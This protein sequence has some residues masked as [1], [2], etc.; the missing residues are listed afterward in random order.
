MRKSQDEYIAHEGNM[1]K[2]R[3]LTPLGLGLNL[4]GTFGSFSV[5]A[6]FAIHLVTTFEKELTTMNQKIDNGNNQIIQRIDFIVQKENSDVLFLTQ[7]EASD[8]LTLNQ[9]IYGC[10]SKQ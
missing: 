1:Q 7:K 6:W 4:I 2:W 5:V 9:K 3:K 8:I 10:C